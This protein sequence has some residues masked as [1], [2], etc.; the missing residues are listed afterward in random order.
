M[1]LPHS[2]STFSSTYHY[3]KMTIQ[4]YL[5]AITW[6]IK[7]IT[8]S[9]GFSLA[10]SMMLAL[11]TSRVD[12]IYATAK[13]W[14]KLLQDLCLHHLRISL[15]QS[16]AQ[17]FNFSEA[18]FTC[19]SIE[20]KNTLLFSN[21]MALK[22]KRASSPTIY[23]NELKSRA[24]SNVHLLSPSSSTSWSSISSTASSSFTT[25]VLDEPDTPQSFSPTLNFKANDQTNRAFFDRYGTKEF[26]S[27]PIAMAVDTW[28]MD[29]NNNGHN[30]Q[31]AFAR[32]PSPSFEPQAMMDCDAVIDTDIDDNPSGRT[33]KRFRDNRP[34]ERTVY[35]ENSAF[36]YT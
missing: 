18:D 30:G 32:K 34:D 24:Q 17:Y 2:C 11:N 19:A 28:R 7:P 20:R 14:L 22:R 8:C 15:T 25:S 35:G 36:F 31:G 12:S 4:Q 23:K 13:N 26:G 1:R 9:N 29:V 33:R 27:S 5:V 21:L 16:I 6:K 10:R 3:R